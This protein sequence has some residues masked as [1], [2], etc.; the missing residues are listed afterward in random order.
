M[1]I[2]FLKHKKMIQHEL[3]TLSVH[4]TFS[5]QFHDFDFEYVGC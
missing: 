3:F 1:I 5:L 2:T 4:S